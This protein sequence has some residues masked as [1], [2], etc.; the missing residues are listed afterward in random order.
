M[1]RDPPSS[2]AVPSSK[3]TNRVP[4]RFLS[5]YLKKFLAFGPR[6]C[7]KWTFKFGN[8]RRG[9]KGRSGSI[10]Y[11]AHYKIRFQPGTFYSH[12]AKT[13]SSRS[14]QAIIKAGTNREHGS[15]HNVPASFYFG[16]GS[17]NEEKFWESAGAEAIIISTLFW[18][19]EF[20]TRF[21]RRFDL[22][23]T[24][25]TWNPQWFLAG[26]RINGLWE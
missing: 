16:S 14:K 11:S 8:E 5:W 20:G 13:G 6:R 7:C 26:G 15:F 25:E 10:V 2:G 24:F 4:R 17:K 19:S 21:V 23:R 9:W 22:E 18:P 1:K 12:V 3:R